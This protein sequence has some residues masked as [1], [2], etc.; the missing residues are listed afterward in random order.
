MARKTV[1]IERGRKPAKKHK[2]FR[3]DADIMAALEAEAQAFGGNISAV[4][5]YLLGVS[6]GVRKPMKTP[7][8][9]AS[10]QKAA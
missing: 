2:G 1:A 10:L 7:R 4:V 9:M 6:L 8:A 5:N 3:I